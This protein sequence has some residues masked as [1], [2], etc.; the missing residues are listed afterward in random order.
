MDFF[1][2]LFK[3]NSVEQENKGEKIFENMNFNSS[4]FQIL[5]L[6][7][8]PREKPKHYF[9]NDPRKLKEIINKWRFEPSDSIGLCAYDYSI[10]FENGPLSSSILVCFLCNRLTIG[11]SIYEISED[12]IR[13]LLKEDFTPIKIIKKAFKNKEEGIKFLKKERNHPDMINLPERLPLWIKHEGKFMV[14]IKLDNSAL[15]G[16]ADFDGKRKHAN[17]LLAKQ[18]ERFSLGDGYSFHFFG[19][20]RGE[21]EISFIFT[22][23]GSKLFFDKIQDLDKY[24]WG[25]FGKFELELFYRI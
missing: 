11:D 17:D 8:R 3:R 16:I 15:S 23:N 9:L 4:N 20:K 12:L 19:I 14:S 5:A 1:K 18:L 21:A 22:V 13:S 6:D 25:W 10:T 7:I 2:S 24:D